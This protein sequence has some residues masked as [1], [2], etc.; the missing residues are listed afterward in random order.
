MKETC[1]IMHGHSGAASGKQTGLHRTFINNEMCA[2]LFIEKKKNSSVDTEIPE[3]QK[4]FPTLKNNSDLF[5]S[6]LNICIFEV[7]TYGL[8]KPVKY[9]ITVISHVEPQMNV[10]KKKNQ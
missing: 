8:Q 2:G 1:T 10:Q 9:S 6:V 7:A 4:C 3:Q 5:K